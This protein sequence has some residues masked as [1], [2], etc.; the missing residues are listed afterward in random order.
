MS[1]QVLKRIA[2]ALL[3]ALG[4]WA[5][6]ARFGSSHRD[7]TTSL[8]LPKVN[9]A[10]VSEIAFRKGTDSVVLTPQGGAWT[11]N[12][13]P[14]SRKGVSAFLASLGDSS[15][16]SEVVAQSSGS[17]VR[18]GV[19]SAAGRRLVITVAGKPAVDLWLGNR[20]PDFEG[21]Y[22]RPSGSDLVYLLQGTFAELTAQGLAE[23][24]EKEF[25][26]IR[27]DSIA[28][29]DVTRGKA[30][31]TLAR[32]AGGW[33]IAGHAADSMKVERYLGQFAGLRASGFPEPAQL[34][35]IRFEHPARTLTLSTADGRALAAL[36]FD[37]AGSGAYWVRGAQGGPVYRLDQRPAE[38][39]TP[40]DSTLRK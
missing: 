39:A 23:W 2:L 30:R 17:H 20:G 34:E 1:A 31:W 11:V 8:A 15:A 40:A 19:D 5:A 16:H 32:S 3:V 24:R 18:M 6:L 27:A 29:V 28:R 33:T 7:D 12:G 21:F 38:M 10:D 4:L 22:V 36:V 14:A 37:T 35:S 26:T 13:L 9:A 25:V